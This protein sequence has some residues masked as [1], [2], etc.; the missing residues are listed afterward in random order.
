MPVCFY[1]NPQKYKKHIFNFLM[2]LNFTTQISQLSCFRIR[3]KGIK[4]RKQ[5]TGRPMD[6]SLLYYLKIVTKL[7]NL[8]SIF[9]LKGIQNRTM[10]KF[11][12]FCIKNQKQLH[13]SLHTE[14]KLDRYDACK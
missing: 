12:Y 8:H 11:I 6:K 2:K 1:I 3:N 10:G 13:C 9:S 7:D 4:R 5:R 14:Y